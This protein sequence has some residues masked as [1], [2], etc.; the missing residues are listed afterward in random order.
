MLDKLTS[1][2]F[3][4]QI[5]RIV[6][7]NSGN[8]YF[9]E[10]NE[11]VSKISNHFVEGYKNF[12][13]NDKEDL[14]DN[15][16]E[17]SS[18]ILESLKSYI[19]N[20]ATETTSLLFSGGKDST[21]IA[22]LLVD[23]GTKVNAY[24]LMNANS[25]DDKKRYKLEKLEII[26][27]NIGLNELNIVYGAVPPATHLEEYQ[28][29]LHTSP[30]SIGLSNIF[31]ST[32]IKKDSSIWFAQGADTLSNAVHTQQFYRLNNK[33]ANA[34]DFKRMLYKMSAKTYPTNVRFISYILTS[35]IIRKIKNQLPIN[36]ISISN[37]SK[38]I[39]MF[40]IHTPFDSRFIYDISK[41]N[42]LKV[43]NPFHNTEIIR[44]FTKGVRELKV[45]DFQKLKPEIEDISQI[46]GISRL[47]FLSN[48]FGISLG[49]SKD[50]KNYMNEIYRIHQLNSLSIE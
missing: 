37:L 41:I 2:I 47:D 26:S 42:N 5:E 13:V 10:L 17:K 43:Y 35:L 40:L 27:R 21:L 6:F 23:S 19:Q 44:L 15:Q 48:S 9:R 30:A 49:S 8:L 29:K 33:Q 25:S 32:E 24:H 12:S 31:K 39:G 14:F 45:S 36:N 1:R 7:L 22:K 20:N 28:N 18:A 46:L 16:H 3:F 50:H 38:I 34:Q 11:F 4:S